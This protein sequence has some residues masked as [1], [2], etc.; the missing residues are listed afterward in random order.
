VTKGALESFATEVRRPEPELDLARAALFIAAGEYRGLAVDSEIARLDAIAAA[1]SDAS[2]PAL[3]P[4]ALAGAISRQ[5]FDLLRFHGNQDDY[6]DP[7]NSY[8]NDVLAR[9][10]G[11]PITLS[12]VYLEVAWRLGLEA[13]GVGYP[14]HFLVKYHDGEQ[15][16]IVDP[17]HGG[18]E[19]ALR[20]FRAGL[21]A[22]RA[23]MAHVLDYYLAALTRRQLLTRILTN[24]KLIY[25]QR[26]DDAR[27]LRIQ[28]YLLALSPWSLPDLR[29]RGVLRGR[30]GD[31]TGAL[32]D[33]ETYLD[34]AEEAD[35]A[36]TIRRL[37]ALLRTGTQP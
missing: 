35:D 23:A 16:W 26:R 31:T 33:L 22:E 1:V 3:S 28:D 13:T 11:I 21:T 9:R 15:E 27:A 7:R 17:F 37:V 24:L 30:T 14:G 32:A 18:Q 19:F 4:R 2:G 6:Y 10:T 29:D 25:H 8:L 34:H 12:V 5:L 36:G 20:E